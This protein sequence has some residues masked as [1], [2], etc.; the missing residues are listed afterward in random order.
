M[1]S[2]VLFYRRMSEAT[3]GHHGVHT[4]LEVNTGVGIVL[5][6]ARVERKGLIGVGKAD[7]ITAILAKS[8]PE[9]I[10]QYTRAKTASLPGQI[11]QTHVIAEKDASVNVAAR[12]VSA[13]RGASPTRHALQQHGMA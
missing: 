3:S 11:V 2:K 4:H 6:I 13:S 7:H 1:V 8:I 10:A 12:V 9:I 5:G